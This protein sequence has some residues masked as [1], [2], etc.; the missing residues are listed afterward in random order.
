MWA[1][2]SSDQAITTSKSNDNFKVQLLAEIKA[3]KRSYSYDRHDDY[4]VIRYNFNF[5]GYSRLRNQFFSIIYILIVSLVSC[6]L[7]NEKK[8]DSILNDIIL[9]NANYMP[10]QSTLV[11]IL[12]ENSKD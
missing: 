6:F 9:M 4:C 5:A 10:L 3:I 2:E 8:K 12:L 11:E 7:F 1:G